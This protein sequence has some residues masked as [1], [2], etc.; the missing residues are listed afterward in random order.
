MAILDAA[1]RVA[2]AEGLEAVSVRRVAAE[3]DAR[4]MSLYSHFSS[5]KELLAAMTD[6]AVE[7]M[8]VPQ[9]LPERWRQALATR[10]RRMLAAFVAHPWL[11]PAF[12]QRPRP[13]PNSMKSAK[14]AAEAVSSLRLAGADVWQVQGIVN[15]YVIGYSFRVFA[16]TDPEDLETALS[17]SDVFEFPE[18]A[19]LPDNMRLRSSLERFELGLQTVFDGIERRFLGAAD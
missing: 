15:D 11:I 5:K 3:L 12:A 7:E 17:H 18:L 14:Q 13:G 16:S 19:E 9:P 6:D 2:D 4:P 10:A 8:L 1:I